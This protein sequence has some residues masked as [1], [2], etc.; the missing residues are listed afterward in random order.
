MYLDKI[1]GP[2]CPQD[3]STAISQSVPSILCYFTAVGVGT[4]IDDQLK[5]QRTNSER[6][7]TDLPRL[8]KLAQNTAANGEVNHEAPPAVVKVITLS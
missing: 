4:S 6:K 1:F 8:K 2:S 3:T 5:Y 7:S